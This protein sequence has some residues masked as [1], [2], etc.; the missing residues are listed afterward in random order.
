MMHK[1]LLLFLNTDNVKIAI[2]ITEFNYVYYLYN[3][4]I[5]VRSNSTDKIWYKIRFMLHLK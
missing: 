4:Y 5:F 1:L 2:T 3:L